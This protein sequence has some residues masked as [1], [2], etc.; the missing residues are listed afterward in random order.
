M[1]VSMLFLFIR[2]W[3]PS[4]F[5]SCSSSSFAVVGAGGGAPP[6]LPCGMLAERLLFPASLISDTVPW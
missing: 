4:S 1:C 5:F 2:T 6:T 3:W